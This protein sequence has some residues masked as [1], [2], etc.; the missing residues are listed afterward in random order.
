MSHFVYRELTPDERR[1]RLVHLLPGDS[2]PQVDVSCTISHVSLDHPPP[3]LALS[4]T[5]GSTHRNCRIFVNG[6]SLNVTESLQVALVHLRRQDGPLILWIDALCIDQ[7]DEVEKTEQVGQMQEI[8]SKATSVITWLGPATESS[9]MAMRW[10]EHYGSLASNIG[11]GTKPELRLLSLLQTLDTSPEKLPHANLEEFL[12]AICSQLSQESV[13]LAL[14]T[15]FG[16]PYWSRVWVVQEL[17]YGR[18][19]RFVCG[20]MTTSEEHLHQTLRLLRNTKQY[21]QS[22]SAKHFQ[23][24]ALWWSN[25][26]GTQSPINILKVRRA[27]GAQGPFPLMYLMRIL[28]NFQATDPRDKIFALLSFARDG[29][30]LGLY[31]DYQA[32][33]KDVYLKTTAALVRSGFIDV[34]SF[35]QAPKT[36]DNLPSWVPD[37]SSTTQ[38]AP[39]QQRALDRRSSP[40]ATVLQPSFN[41]CGDFN[42]AELADESIPPSSCLLALRAK[43]V[44]E[45]ELVGNTWE[46]G[47]FSRWLHELKGFSRRGAD[48][49]DP[50][51]VWRAA[52][53]DQEIRQGGDKPRLPE[54][55]Q[56]RVHESLRGL[57]LSTVDAQTFC[58]LGLNDYAHQLEDVARA[59]RPF[60]TTGGYFGIGPC[61]MKPGDDVYILAGAQ[62]P[63]VIRR[64]T[65]SALH[66]VGEAYV[67]GIMDGEA[68][69]DG[70]A[71]PR[72][73][74]LS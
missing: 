29:Q 57:D 53:A 26:L 52:V 56:D 25:V 50:K 37:F 13:V 11:I 36:I 6:A 2:D 15:L 39:F 59:R 43:L 41:A 31:P 71:I 61:G 4:Y 28:R 63:Y 68:A 46:P 12:K 45:V 34:L 3:Y 42:D 74:N 18:S 16:R 7:T 17:A 66:L 35:C 49:L 73:I 8:Y 22:R 72:T 38:T 65:S 47:R 69:N 19:V 33:C 30:E 60:C 20:N 27:R 58:S 64:G 54:G 1:I 21:Y 62:V 10:I 14:S 32:S 70:D 48:T 9:D 44:G 51:A 55:L 67:D 40:S 23:S 24:A 5:W